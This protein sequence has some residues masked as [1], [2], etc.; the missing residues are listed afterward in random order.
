M[1]W[2]YSIYTFVIIVDVAPLR[3]LLK[4]LI[5]TGKN[6]IYIYIYIYIYILNVC[7][8]LLVLVGYALWINIVHFVGVIKECLIIWE[9]MK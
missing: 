1:Y 2:S 3:Y 4:T 7:D 6:L 8:W 5:N 9:C